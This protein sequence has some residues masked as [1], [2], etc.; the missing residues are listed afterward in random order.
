MLKADASVGSIA[1]RA[2]PAMIVKRK[3]YQYSARLARPLN[4]AYFE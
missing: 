2:A 1:D 3:K 4:V